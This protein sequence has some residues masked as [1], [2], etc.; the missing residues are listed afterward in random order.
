MNILK[1]DLPDFK[2]KD[3]KYYQTIS[4]EYANAKSLLKLYPENPSLKIFIDN[5]ASRNIEIPEE[6]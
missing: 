6:S 4:M 1:R 5:L 3:H 2:P